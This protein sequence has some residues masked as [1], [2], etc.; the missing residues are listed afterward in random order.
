MTT[1]QHMAQQQRR[2]DEWQERGNLAVRI[3]DALIE[4]QQAEIDADENAALADLCEV[5][6]LVRVGKVADLI[7]VPA[8][9]FIVNTPHLGGATL[10]TYAAAAR[11]AAAAIKADAA[12]ITINYSEDGVHFTELWAVRS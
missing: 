12:Y 2:R 6:H 7:N 9:R 11:Q 1:Q 8:N 5:A 4:A 10:T 3:E